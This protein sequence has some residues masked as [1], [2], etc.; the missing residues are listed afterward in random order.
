MSSAIR[1][2][3]LEELQTKYVEWREDLGLSNEKILF[4]LLEKERAKTEYLT[5]RLDSL[6]AKEK[7]L[8]RG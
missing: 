3:I 6:S 8:A 2:E 5:K 4:T 7:I 1:I